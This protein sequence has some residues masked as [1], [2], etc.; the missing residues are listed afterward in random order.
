MGLDWCKAKM[1]ARRQHSASSSISTLPT[2]STKDALK[3]LLDASRNESKEADNDAAAHNV[4]PA[5]V[6]LVNAGPAVLTVADA[7]QQQDLAALLLTRL[8]DPPTSTQPSSAA[9]SKKC[10]P[11]L[12]LL[13]NLSRAS[14]PRLAQPDALTTLTAFVQR[15][16][17]LLATQDNG[18]TKEKGN[19]EPSVIVVDADT[20]M[21]MRTLN[22]MLMLHPT[23]RTKFSSDLPIPRTTQVAAATDKAGAPEQAQRASDSEG[24]ETTMINGAQATARLL[25]AISATAGQEQHAM[26]VFLAA[27]LL[28]FSTLFENRFVMQAVERERLVE[29]YAQGVCSLTSSSLGPGTAA[30]AAQ[31][32]ALAELL[33]LAFNVSLYYP[34]LRPGRALAWEAKQD[35]TDGKSEATAPPSASS[36]ATTSKQATAGEAWAEE[37]EGFAEPT[38]KLFVKLSTTASTSKLALERPP[39]EA[40]MQQTISLMLN[41]PT[42]SSL[43]S[44]GTAPVPGASN[45]KKQ[46][47]SNGSGTP[48]PPD[49]AP[50]EL[51][52]VVKVFELLAVALHRYFPP[53]R[54]SSVHSSTS[55]SSSAS[56]SQRIDSLRYATADPDSESVLN[57]ARAQAAKDGLGGSS[58]EGGGKEGDP[59]MV[60]EPL[61]LLARKYVAEDAGGREGVRTARQSFRER[62]LPDNLDRSTPPHAQ[63]TLTGLLIRLISSV[64]FPRLARAAGELLLAV[65]NGNPRELSSTV[66]YGPVAGFLALLG[67]SIEIPD[68]TDTTSSTTDAG[69]TPSAKSGSSRPVDPITGRFADHDEADVSSAD[70][71]GQDGMTPEEREREA[72]RLFVLFERLNRTGVM[73]VANPALDPQTR[74][75]VEELTE[76]EERAERE[77]EER[78]EREEE[79]EAL[80]DLEAYKARKAKRGG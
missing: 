72:E 46:T 62:L 63:A 13:R 75:K 56:S 44:T 36:S 34:R 12:E 21:A 78:E 18:Q 64:M 59:E 6:A 7:Q 17:H 53:A 22:N 66:G 74:A 29:S 35:E 45:K 57:A 23:L 61:V 41:M 19:R 9:E 55:S 76:E 4:L 54:R 11:E 27:R 70:G 58:G 39:L 65:C 51:D 73:S 42:A 40:P 8:Q 25:R 60:L 67:G 31:T 37:L 48:N 3:L 38:V 2:L 24:K 68:G 14:N 71:A 10:M 50:A 43:S 32:Q 77:R 15:P 80:R 28:F 16:L 30:A 33:K 47:D 79:Q 49:T 52:V 5:L 69:Q 20:D 26:P 1:V